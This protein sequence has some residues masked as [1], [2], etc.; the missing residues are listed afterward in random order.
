[1]GTFTKLRKKEMASPASPFVYRYVQDE[2]AFDAAVKDLHGKSAYA[3]DSEGVNLGRSP[4]SLT[5]ATISSLDNPVIYVIDVQVLGG[6]KVFS[7]TEPSLAQILEGGASIITLDCRSDSDALFHHFGV[8]LANVCDVQILDQA[9]RILS[10]EL[11]P[12]RCIFLTDSYVPHLASMGAVAERLG[13]DIPGT[14]TAPHKLDSKAWEKRPLKE[15]AIAYAA[16]DVQFIREMHNKAWTMVRMKLASLD[17]NWEKFWNQLEAS[18]KQHS[19]RYVAM[20]RDR[21]EPPRHTSSQYFLSKDERDFIIEEHP[22]VDELHLPVDHPRK[23]GQQRG[24]KGQEKLDSAIQALKSTDGGIK[25]REKAFIDVMFVL[26]H[27]RW[28]TDVTRA[29][30]R[31]LA[32]QFPFTANQRSKI[33]NLPKLRNDDDDSDY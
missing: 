3:F 18:Y 17:A 14:T 7:R 29:E 27:D 6:D 12:K 31:R 24:R 2:A 4:G 28:Y 20:Y 19:M 26:Q 25:V 32:G 30:I 8:K 1:V 9:E 5:A 21:I 16:S 11:P 23:L 13:V 22:I 15:E 10:G 33:S